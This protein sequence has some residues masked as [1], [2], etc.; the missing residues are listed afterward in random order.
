[1]IP[2]RDPGALP[3]TLRGLPPVDEVIIVRETPA[4]VPAGPASASSRSASPAD[5]AATVRAARPDARVL[6]AGRP[7]PGNALATGLA[8]A[9]CDVVVTLNGDGS[10]DPAEIPRYVAALVAGADVAVGSR[11][12]EGGR[13]LT[14]GRFRRWANVLLIWVVNTLFGVRRTDPGFGYAAFWRD[15]LA[16]LDLPG[17]SPRTG[18]ARHDPSGRTGTA[19]HD[20]SARAGAAWGDGPG[21]SARI[22]GRFDRPGRTGRI[23]AA[24][25]DGPELGPLLTL[26]PSI[27]GLRVAEVA[28]VAY[29]RMN[30]PA[31]AGRIGLRH[32]LRLLATEYPH[33]QGRHAAG[34]DFPSEAPA[35]GLA[36]GTG[37][38]A[39]GTGPDPLGT[40]GHAPGPGGLAAGPGDHAAGPGG[41][42]PANGGRS[43][44]TG[45]AGSTADLGMAGAG[46]SD[47]EWPGADRR[48]PGVPIWAPSRRRP[49]PSRDLWLAGEN[50][51]PH[52]SPR[53]IA[54]VTPHAWR[55]GYPGRAAGPDAK[56]RWAEDV[57]P[58]SAASP[59]DSPAS[60]LGSAP[61]LDPASGSDSA[62]EADPASRIDPATPGF[63]PASGWN[64][65]SPGFDPA[66][67]GN[68]AAPCFDP[69]A[70]GLFPPRPPAAPRR[71]VGTKRRRIEGLRQRPDLRVING[72]GNGSGRTRS[73]RLRPVPKENLGGG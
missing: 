57:R 50:P 4:A 56:P 63:D 37:G 64:P 62:S 13:D 28:S 17:P 42:A 5:V 49:S 71:E 40:G 67:G 68:S 12:R 51:V 25:G 30:R 32:W 15:A 36:P 10:T 47:A 70:P 65:R 33:R 9:S 55:T 60:S 38:H 43:A 29:P 31:R 69:A 61:S 20:P 34:A 2:V 26:R 27:R 72:E 35:G 8:A 73:G 45:R 44:G 11:Y 23:G 48:S 16:H 19:R 3:L 52:T 22:G 14:G 6:A 7:G 59:W 21:P 54:N 39:P 18:A 46:A 41:L 53:S 24:W 58:D 1:M 66:S